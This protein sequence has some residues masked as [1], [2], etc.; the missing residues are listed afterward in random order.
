MTTIADNRTLIADDDLDP[1]EAYPPVALSAEYGSAP[2]LTRIGWALVKRHFTTLPEG[3]RIEFL[4]KARGG[5]SNGK[6]TLGKCIKMGGLALHFAETDY[7]IWLAADHIDAL[8]LDRYQVE[9]LLFHELCHI[10][11]TKE[12]EKVTIAVNAHDLEAFK[13]EVEY[14][15]FWRHDLAAMARTMQR[16]LPGFDEGLAVADPPR[17]V[18]PGDELVHI[19]LESEEDLPEMEPPAV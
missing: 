7:V 12:E 15:G 5:S 18:R 4:W 9:A 2:D 13:A 3:V 10:D 17:P 16:R 1:D 8:P 6:L 19:V 11:A 14:Y